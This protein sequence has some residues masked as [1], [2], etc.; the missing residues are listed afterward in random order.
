MKGHLVNSM[1]VTVLIFVVMVSIVTTFS[2]NQL[3]PFAQAIE[4][5]EEL[6]EQIVYEL[7]ITLMDV[8]DVD[9]ANGGYSFSFWLRLESEQ[10][11]FTQT[12]VPAI[13]FVN[14]KIDL[15]EHEYF[16]D[17]HTYDAK[18]HGTFFTNMDF[19]N[20]PIMDLSLPVMI[21][22]AQYPADQIKFVV[23]NS[24]SVI[25][26]DLTISGLIYDST[27]EEEIDY[28]YDDGRVFSRYVTTFNFETP[29][30]TSFLVGIFPI[31][32]MAILVVFLFGLDP[33]NHDLKVEMIIG[34]LIA[35][36]FFHVLDVGESLP[37]L[38]YLTLEDKAMTVLYAMLGVIMIETMSQ[39]RWNED[40]DVDKAKKI[41][42][43][44]RTVFIIVVIVT[45][46]L[47]SQL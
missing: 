16:P 29:F 15:I 1:I 36:V 24:V 40:D 25:N 10:V 43:K 44:F 3:I 21:E 19:H 6:D 35:A 4:I 17:K 38:E 7:S 30:L 8:S 33:R 37:P 13:D 27:D 22:P 9:Y 12:P 26:E 2:H 34:V 5:F 23:G 39:I 20:Y 45:I 31:L 42:K 14:G 32:I 41:D 46:A 28:T 18:V 47:V 11:D